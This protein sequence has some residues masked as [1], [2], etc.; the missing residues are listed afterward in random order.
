MTV[1]VAATGRLGM[2][3]SVFVC[4]GRD[5]RSEDLAKLRC[6]M[7]VY[8]LLL[9]VGTISHAAAFGCVEMVD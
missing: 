2:V 7:E 8:G 9:T 3:L 1:T 6:L 5:A 4:K